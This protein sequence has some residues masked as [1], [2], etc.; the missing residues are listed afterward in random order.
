VNG[1]QAEVD[2]EAL[3]ALHAS[4]FDSPWDAEALAELLAQPGT[5]LEVAPGEGFILLRAVADEAEVLTLAVGPEARRKGLGLRLVETG[6]ARAAAMGAE[7]VFLEVA[8]DNAA[9]LALYA[10][11]GFQ[12]VGRRRG[13]YARPD[14]SRRDALLLALNLPERLPSP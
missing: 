3:A 14:G 6:V 8:D 9:A 11:C 1:P 4:A 7:R 12:A 2:A 5:I 13:Y 10:R